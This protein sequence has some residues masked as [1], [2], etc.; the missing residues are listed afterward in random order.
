[1]PMTALGHAELLDLFLD[2]AHS[3]LPEIRQGVSTLEREGATMSTLEELHRLFHNIKGAASQVQLIHL[4]RGAKIVENLLAEIVEEGRPMPVDLPRILA[5][6]V[7]LLE[8]FIERRDGQASSEEGFLLQISD[9]FATLD[10]TGEVVREGDNAAHA[11]PLDNRE[12]ILAARSLLPLLVEMAGFLSPQR[13]VAENAKVYASLR[14]GVAVL[15]V[16]AKADGLRQH[17]GLLEEFGELLEKLHSQPFNH[18]PETAGLI[19]D[20]LRFLEVVY[21]YN[22]PESHGTV[23]R[24]RNQLRGVQLLLGISAEADSPEATGS[25][26]I[27]TQHDQDEDDIFTPLADN[28][29]LEQYSDDL[30]LEDD[31]EPGTLDIA[32]VIDGE[33]ELSGVVEDVSASREDSEQQQLLEIFHAECEEHLINAN[34]TLN[35][36]EHEV[37]TPRPLHDQLRETISVMRRAVHTLKGAAAMTGMALTARGAHRLEDLLDWLHDDAEEITPQ[38]VALIADGIDVIELLAQGIQSGEPPRLVGFEEG[39]SR[40]LSQRGSEGDGSGAETEETA[41]VPVDL[42]A[43][44]ETD[45]KAVPSGAMPTALPGDSGILRVRLD[46]LDELVGIE[47]ELIVARGAMEKMVEEFSDTV[48]ELDT[49][50]ENLRRKSQELESGFEGQSLYGLNPR[51]EGG[52]ADGEFAE[53]DPIELD[54]YSQLN[55]IIRSLN[56]I[57]VDVNSIATTLGAIA[58]DLRGQISKQQLTMRLMQEKLMRIRMTPMSTLSRILFRTVRETARN[59]G[60]KANLAITG[61]DVYMDRFVWAKITDPL[62]HM[63]RNALDHGIEHPAERLAAGKAESGQVSVAAEQRSRFAILRISDDGRGIDVDRVRQRALDRGLITPEQRISEKE[64]LEFLFHPSFTTRSDVGV[65]SGRGVGLDVVRRNIQELHGSIQLHNRPG[66]GVTFEISIPFTLSVNRALIVAVAGH[67]FAVPLQHIYQVKRFARQEITISDNH[68][69]LNHGEEKIEA[70]NLG[71]YLQL[72]PRRHSL[73]ADSE[74]GVLAILC[75]REE[76]LAAVIIEE[77]VEQREIVVKN[78]G[79]HL[80][81]VPGISGVTLTG[82]GDMIPITNIRE[83]FS[84]EKGATVATTEVPVPT[85]ASTA[86]LKVLIVDDSISVRHS[87]TRLVEGQGWKQQQ[88]VDGVEALAKLEQFLPDV[89][90]LDI[91]MPRMNGYELKSALNNNERYRE[92]PVIMLTSRASEKHQQKAKELG[93]RHYMTKPYQEEVFIRLLEKLH[94][95]EVW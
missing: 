5:Q 78:L 76:R 28:G 65:I 80:T 87:V 67:N 83:L 68:L 91:E 22:D 14:Q 39:V 54:R 82:S 16:S 18:L 29:L 44:V 43:W 81:H 31:E 92:I 90:I 30:F 13:G 53:F 34:R 47:G 45:A 35:T 15:A 66:Q 59:L 2:E 38:E 84:L 3:Y 27:S 77:I 12:Y 63:L 55:L 24:V 72:D 73:S 25:S 52:T 9:L 42:Q 75:H 7:N 50:K 85:T 95:G 41:E 60:K 71:Y 56:E 79:S 86:P 19:L 61:E 49:V 51:A 11:E 21:T 48:F 88:A 40:Y 17:F 6:G 37:V 94:R 89:I 26:A 23:Q 36:L 33:E 58:G 20:F 32:A 93:I 4:S 62:M 70:I 69:L 57:S 64:L 46:D 10:A 8:A 74:E 1:M